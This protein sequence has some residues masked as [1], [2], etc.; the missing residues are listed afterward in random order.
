MKKKIGVILLVISIVLMSTGIII[1]F[2]KRFSNI[3]LYGIEDNKNYKY[4]DIIN[5]QISVKSSLFIN[6]NKTIWTLNGYDFY[7]GKEYNSIPV[8]IGNN[9]LEIRNENKKRKYKFNISND[10]NDVLL[11][12]TNQKMSIDNLDYDLD[13]LTNIEEQKLGLK[14]YSNDSDGDKLLDNV[15]LVLNTNP[16]KKD[17]YNKIRN[18]KVYAN[19]NKDSNIFI[20]VKSKGNIANSFIDIIDDLE[21]FFPKNFIKSKIVNVTTTNEVEPESIQVTFENIN[22]NLKDYEIYAYNKITNE[23]RTLSSSKEKNSISAF[24]PGFEWYCMIGDKNMSPQKANNQIEILI[25][26]SG[27]MYTAD[28]VSKTTNTEIPEEELKEYGNDVDF[29]RIELMKQLISKL[30][31]EKYSYKI[32]G[33]TNGTCNLIDWSNDKDKLYSKLDSLKNEC[34]EFNG[35]YT[36][37]AIRNSENDF[38][39]NSLGVK[40]MIVLT[41]GKDTDSLFQYELYNFELESIKKKGIKIITIGL[42][43]VDS[44]FLQNI[45]IKTDGK[46]LYSTDSNMLTELMTTIVSSV[47]S[48]TEKTDEGTNIIQGDSGFK[49]NRDGFNFSNFG[50]TDSQ[51]GNCFGFALLSKLIYLDKLPYYA[52]EYTPKNLPTLLDMDTTQIEYTLTEKNKQRLKKGKVNDLKLNDLYLSVVT[53]D[54]EINDLRVLNKDNIPVINDKYRANMLDSGFKLEM[55]TFDEEKEI[56]YLKDHEHF[57]SNK[58]ESSKLNC[59]DAKVSDDY[60]D[61]YQVMQLINRYFRVQKGHITKQLIQNIEED[62]NLYE[63]IGIQHLNKK[64]NTGS[65][66]ILGIECIEGG[67]A[68]L[69]TRLSKKIDKD[70]YKLYIYDSNVP[71]EE[72]KATLTRQV[73]KNDNIIGNK[74]VFN[75]K[76][77]GLEFYSIALN[78]YDI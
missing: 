68:I 58:C 18:Y 34:Q 25:D 19:N 76:A 14:T 7:E 45:A 36:S 48:I 29:K 59:F 72:T 27:S 35:T 75:Y 44:D 5:K 62:D 54:K 53:K 51:M 49:V 2:G 70:E 41:D 60:K 15:E 77:A 65:P 46:Y 39:S 47:F 10:N 11:Q 6:K 1:I 69:G 61:D 33:Y 63:K 71:N 67:H 20:D 21:D 32:K 22:K 30:G 28:Y 4:Q 16:L 31:T 38:D 3:D 50:S 9:E 12:E 66:V 26:N 64:L 13:G 57:K 52:P 8:K 43:N 37:G 73:T 42:G 23:L 74:Y 56:L 40:Y 78:D 24:I 55:V 17:N